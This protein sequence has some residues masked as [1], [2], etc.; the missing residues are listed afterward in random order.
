LGLKIRDYKPKNKGSLMRVI[1]IHNQKGGVG[2]TTTAVNTCGALAELNKS[3]LLIDLDPQGSSTNWL[4]VE[5]SDKGSFELLYDVKSDPNAL[6]QSTD[7]K[8]IS[9]IPSSRKIL[10]IENALAGKVG[11]KLLLKKQIEKL[12]Q[13]W[14]V[15]IIDTPRNPGVLTFNA[16]VA[17]NE[18]VIPIQPDLLS[19]S[20]LF[21]VLETIEQ[22][23][24]QLNPSLI[25]KGILACCVDSSSNHAVE[26]LE[27]LKEKF[28]DKVF[29]SNIRRNIKIVE[30]Y[31]YC[32]PVNTYAPKSSG[33][34]DYKKFTKELLGNK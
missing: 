21:Q 28:K 14:D 30:S 16:L 5:N 8:N 15:I 18:I 4:G 31:S 29:N 13:K 22:V 33:A 27:Q 20:G 1:T 17:A 2:K 3:V 19:C 26:V 10:S 11:A 25:V 6:V 9:I 23:Q 32:Q 7:F 34:E 12:S 24:A